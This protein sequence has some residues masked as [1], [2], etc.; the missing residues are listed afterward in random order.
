[1]TSEEREDNYRKKVN[2]QKEED[3]KKLWFGCLISPHGRPMEKYISVS[4]YIDEESLGDAYDVEGR[5]VSE[6][7]EAE[8]R[9]EAVEKYKEI[10]KGME[11]GYI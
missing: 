5:Y 2:A 4:K 3:D 8:D 6:P 11:H 1:M 9:K 10:L 7:F